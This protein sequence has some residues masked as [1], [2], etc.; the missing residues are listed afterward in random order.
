MKIVDEFK[1]FAFKGNVL[2][3]AV[4]VVIGAAF[5]KIVSSFVADVI[6]PCISLLTGGNTLKDLYLPLSGHSAFEGA[7]PAT[8]EAANE[9]GIATL[10]Y[11]SFLQNIIDFLIIAISVFIFVK[12]IN[13]SRERAQKL[14]HKK[15]AAEAEN[16]AAE[17]AAAAAEA[18]PA[19]KTCPYCFTEINYHATRCPNCTSV[20]TADAEQE[21]ALQS[22]GVSAAAAENAEA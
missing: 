20:L 10:N 21:A 16:A 9:A 19:T 22:G 14:L 15:E 5:G 2:D 11:G 4:G 6:T 1:K 17:A 12:L 13:T 8:V 7:L 3:M 18:V